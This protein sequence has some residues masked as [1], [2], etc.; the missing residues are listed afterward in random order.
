MVMRFLT[1][2]VLPLKICTAFSQHSPLEISIKYLAPHNSESSFFNTGLNITF[3]IY[4]NA[5]ATVFSGVGNEWFHVQLPG[6]TV[7]IENLHRFSVPVGFMVELKN[8]FRLNFLFDPSISSDIVD[9][10]AD[11]FRFNAAIRLQK[12]TQPGMSWSVGIGF[13]KQ[14]FGIQ[15]IPFYQAVIPITHRLTLSGALPLKPK[16]TWHI[17]DTRQWG[18]ALTGNSNSFRLSEGKQGRYAD[19]KQ[20]ELNSFYQQKLIGNFRI[21]G[22]IGLVFINRIRVFDSN[23]TIPL[24]LFLYDFGHSRA[25]ATSWDNKSLSFQVQIAW[26]INKD[27][28]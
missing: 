20:L 6:D 21:T 4:R 3:P 19:V 7:G 16:L 18:F 5:S 28:N 22:S 26:I 12:E 2:L 13:S 8:N 10:S 15:I 23:Q 25:P 24:R 27:L 1:F 14:F 9:I 11:D 17:N